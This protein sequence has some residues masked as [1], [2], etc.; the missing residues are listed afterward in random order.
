MIEDKQNKQSAVKFCLKRALQTRPERILSSK[1]LP[2]VP[3][4]SQPFVAS[5]KH[6]D[7]WE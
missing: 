7:H 6:S 2:S 1:P 4:P 3:S 5:Q